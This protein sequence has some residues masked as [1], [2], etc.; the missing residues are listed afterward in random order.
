MIGLYIINYF[1]GFDYEFDKLPSLRIW[2]F[3]IF[4][5]TVIRAV[6]FDS[7]LPEYA[8]TT[9]SQYISLRLLKLIGFI[10]T[11]WAIHFISEYTNDKFSALLDV[12]SCNFASIFKPRHQPIFKSFYYCE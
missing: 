12:Y 10:A 5:V 11:I 7:I 2:L 8:T 9:F 6:S 4:T 1:F 3:Y